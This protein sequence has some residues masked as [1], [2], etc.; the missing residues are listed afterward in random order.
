MKV[1]QGLNQYY[2]KKFI[3]IFLFASFNIVAYN[4]L[5]KGT[6]LEKKTNNPISAA[7]YFNGTFVGTLSDLKGNFELDVSNN[8]SMPLTISSIGY[9][10][11]TLTEFLTTKPLIIYL[12]PKV[13]EVSEVVISSKSLARRRITN[14][15]LFKKVFLGSTT[16]ALNCKIINE[17]DITFNYANDRDT[18]KA[19]A[20]KPILIHNMSLGYNITYYLDRFEYFKKDR[21]FSFAGNL[22][23]TE[24]LA[25]DETNKQLYELKRKDSYLGSRMHFFRMLWADDLESAGFKVKNSSKMNLTY[26]DIV[27]HSFT[28]SPNDHK[29]FLKYTKTLSVFYDTRFTTIDF[30]TEKVYFDKDGYF[31][32][33]VVSLR[34]EGD[35]LEKRV[36]DMLPYTYKI[37]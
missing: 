21:T 29:K 3:L 28:N 5:I 13:Y 24:D 9:Y 20:S 11:V 15:N 23:F 35:M 18:L 37:E 19:F 2:M 25:S 1:G 6:V 14:L 36:G 10:S 22:I 32:Q 17:N 34:W 27:V 7:I 4:Q 8:V 33:T 26:N 31:D 12:T 30:L 16:N